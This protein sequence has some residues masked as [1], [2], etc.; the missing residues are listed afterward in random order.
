MRNLCAKLNEFIF[1]ADRFA[2]EDHH[3][4]YKQKIIATLKSSIE[5]ELKILATK[6]R[7]ACFYNQAYS[8]MYVASNKLCYYFDTKQQDKIPEQIAIVIAG[9]T[10]YID[11]LK[12]YASPEVIQKLSNQLN[13]LAVKQNIFKYDLH[14]LI[15]LNIDRDIIRETLAITPTLVV[16]KL[17]KEVSALNLEHVEMV[18]QNMHALGETGDRINDLY[19]YLLTAFSQFTMAEE[20]YTVIKFKLIDNL[21]L[22]MEKEF[23]Q[24]N[25]KVIT[26][27]AA[28]K[29]SGGSP[30]HKMDNNVVNNQA[31]LESDQLTC[32]TNSL[33]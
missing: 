19:S 26:M 11:V 22:A 1:F 16:H 3:A 31:E 20:P 15:M 28:L 32:E 33:K 14:D 7:L 27:I 5:S 10:K 8:E 23:S 6:E 2:K 17:L 18:K 13:T 12:G 9:I 4:G 29:M 24:E 21:I 25:T 30:L